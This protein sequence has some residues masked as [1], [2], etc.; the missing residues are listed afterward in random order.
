MDS[1]I[2]SVI[3]AA[4]SARVHVHLRIDPTSIDEIERAREWQKLVSSSLNV[5]LDFSVSKDRNLPNAINLG[6]IAGLSRLEMDSRVMCCWLGADDVLGVGAIDHINAIVTQ[7]VQIKFCG[8][9]RNTIDDNGV[10]SL[11]PDSVKFSQSNLANGLADNISMPV[12]QAEG[13]FF[14]WKIFEDAGML[15]E[16]LSYAFDFDI[17]QKIAQTTPYYNINVP[18]GAFRVR[19]GQ[20]SQVRLSDYRR[21]I[22]VAKK[23]NR[24]RDF[25]SKSQSAYFYY[26]SSRFGGHVTVKHSKRAKDTSLLVTTLI[27]LIPRPLVRSASQVF[28]ALGLLKWAQK[29]LR[30]AQR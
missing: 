29:L 17:W 11:S 10:V 3:A 4:Q 30:H 7:N 23:I 1:A 27:I 6:F 18:L 22:S 14:E 24:L 9:L 20:L 13:V 12:V 5:S 26:V 19:V 16:E 25:S 2:S 21:E 15:S 8:G 28:M